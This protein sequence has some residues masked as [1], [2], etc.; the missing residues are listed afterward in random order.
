MRF[1]NIFVKTFVMPFVDYVLGLR[2]QK[3]LRWLIEI[4]WKS[5]DEI[6]SIQRNRLIKTLVYAYK[7]VP[8]YKD[9]F[10]NLGLDIGDIH[11]NPFDVLKAMPYLDKQTIKENLPNRI[12]NG[13]IRKL[14][15]TVSSGSTGEQGTFYLNKDALSWTYGAELLTW[16]WAHFQ[17]GE[18]HF[19]TGMAFPRG[20]LKKT[21]DIILRTKYAPAFNLSDNDLEKYVVK[22]ESGSYRFL[23]GYASSIYLIARKTR[24][25]GLNNIRFNSIITWGDNLFPHYR[26]LIE[27]QFNSK[28]Y[29]TYGAAEGLIIAG[30]CDNG[31]YHVIS[32]H[33]FIEVLRNGKQVSPGEIG[34]VYV[35][36]LDMNP[37]P[38]IRYR[39]GDIAKVGKRETC[40]CGRGFE[41]LASIEGR[42]TDIIR[43]KNG[44]N[45]IVHY[46]TRIF[47]YYPEIKFFQVIQ[48]NYDSITIKI[49][50]SSGF[51]KSLLNKIRPILL[52]DC[53]NDVDIRFQIVDKIPPSPSGKRRFVIS[54]ISFQ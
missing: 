14:Q 7:N 32:P 53:N 25:M 37:M 15:R 43:T 47:E 35:T 17:F 13:D 27:S 5:R 18:K 28:V 31:N 29:D 21:K 52:K 24:E 34:E 33:V 22:L 2:V 10:H 23:L 12:V 6:A 9:V 49:V 3:Y 4:Q 38:L 39:I 20:F 41:Y 46:F 50:P 54:K 44:H 16:L 51:H 8:Y 1:Y 45:L 26:D 19:Q 11:R 36:R 48:N 40:P 42:N 30:Q